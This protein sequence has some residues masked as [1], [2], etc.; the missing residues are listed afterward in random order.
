MF[1]ELETDTESAVPDAI[2]EDA[3]P[4]PY[5][6][7]TA[8]DIVRLDNGDAEILYDEEGR[9]TFIRGRYS[10]EKVLNYEDAVA[11]LNYVSTLLG[12]TNG[13]LFFCV[14]QGIDYTTGY[15]SYLFLQRDGDVTV[16]NAS[17]K[18]YVDPDGYTAALSCSFNPAT[19]IREE[20]AGSITA[21]QAE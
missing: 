13:A 2:Q 7:M 3:Q 18:I 21:A 17:I 11:S 14:Y 12:L 9:V 15:T 5:P 16:V 1:E 20:T 4:A 8:E 6:Q 19:G 10:P